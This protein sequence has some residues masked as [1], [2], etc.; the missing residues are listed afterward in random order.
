[1]KTKNKTKITYKI[2][3]LFIILLIS[4]SVLMPL[5]DTNAKGNEMVVIP[6]KA[7]RLR[8]LANSD[9]SED[10]AL[11]RKVRDEVN[12]Q[13]N[14]W[15]KDLTTFEEGQKVIKS[16]IPD[17]QK[18]V[19]RVIKEEGSNQ[20]FTITYS[21]KVKF[22]TKLYGSFLYPAGDYEAVL[23]KLGAGQGANWWCV[24][25]PPLCFLD[26][27]NGDATLSKESLQ[28]QQRIDHETKIESEPKSEPKNEA[29]N[30][31]K[32][33]EA[34]RLSDVDSIA[35]TKQNNESSLQ[36]DAEVKSSED[37]VVAST[38]PG[39]EPKEDIKVESFFVQMLKQLF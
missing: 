34:L 1:M 30:E 28:S 24:L 17:L 18:T 38:L 39:D 5:R 29:K 6:K 2:I 37:A 4:S 16:H 22:P 21:K 20:P 26:F 9:S 31:F 36:D 25:F 7:V 32:Q 35:T 14:T 12:A 13:I 8:I 3:S 19:A 33:Q 15:V 23:I 27:S 10:Q 11:K